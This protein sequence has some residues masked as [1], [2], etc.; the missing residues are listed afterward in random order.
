MSDDGLE[1]ITIF[2]TALAPFVVL[3]WTKMA[4]FRKT[5]VTG[6]PPRLDLLGR[7]RETQIVDTKPTLPAGLSMR[8]INVK[9]MLTYARDLCCGPQSSASLRSSSLCP[10]VETHAGDG[11]R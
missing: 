11:L 5:R 8:S 9:N 1:I 10:H 3:N 2:D 7:L 6:G 4:A